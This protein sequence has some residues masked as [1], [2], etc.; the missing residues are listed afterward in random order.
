MAV[1]SIAVPPDPAS[2]ARAAALV[3]SV[4]TWPRFTLRR[5]WGSFAAGTVFRRAPS[6]MGND[7]RYLVNE[8]VCTCPDY[9]CNGAIC[10]HIRA[11]VLFEQQ[12]A[13][14]SPLA[15][16]EDLFPVC[17]EPGCDDEPV[18]EGE[19]RCRRH[20]LVDAF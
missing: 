4:A 10:K 15:R 19:G 11:L 12:Q 9:Q 2:D 3:S 20:V 14:P 7:T 1:S 17:R 13:V 5:P 18:R 16:Y 6:S 8:V